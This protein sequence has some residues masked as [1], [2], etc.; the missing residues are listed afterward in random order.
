[1]W[2]VGASRAGIVATGVLIAISVAGCGGGSGGGAST[3]A[4]SL[5][6]KSGL[7]FVPASATSIAGVQAQTGQGATLTVNGAT[8]S[9]VTGGI[10]TGN[11]TLQGTSSNGLTQAYANTSGSTAVTVSKDAGA[12]GQLTD[13]MYGVVVTSNSAGDYLGSYHY[14]TLTPTSS[15]PTT[16]ATYSGKFV[17]IEL[18][19]SKSVRT[20]A[21]NSTLTANFGAGTVSGG[22]TGISSPTTNTL[23]NYGLSMNGTIS[24]NTYSGTTAFTS[25]GGGAPGT[26]TA[27]S[28]NG[29]F[30]GAGASQTAGSLTIQG[31][32]TGY[33]TLAI[34]GAFGGKK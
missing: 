22:I 8:A 3:A 16:T 12:A 26:V 24:G 32:P 30:Y 27:S 2:V 23:T 4:A 13:A 15:M 14:G 25:V 7:L 9:L 20:L 33:S 1:M 5:P 29:G 21:G 17:G 31:T 19:A 10:S 6:G 28:L 11:L 18:N 34:T